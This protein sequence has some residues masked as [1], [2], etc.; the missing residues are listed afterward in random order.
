MST[1]GIIS[2]HNGALQDKWLLPMLP[3][4]TKS[5]LYTQDV[6]GKCLGYQPLKHLEIER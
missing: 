4:S 6:S 3:S 2:L 5:S 1:N